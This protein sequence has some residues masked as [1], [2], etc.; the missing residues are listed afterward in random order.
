MTEK[1][2]NRV[3][4]PIN[5]HRNFVREFAWETKE[6]GVWQSWIVQRCTPTCDAYLKESYLEFCLSLLSSNCDIVSPVKC[7]FEYSK[8]ILHISALK[9][10]PL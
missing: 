2:K 5:Y 1:K 8:P 3:P 10:I 6:E 4:D 9:S 7:S